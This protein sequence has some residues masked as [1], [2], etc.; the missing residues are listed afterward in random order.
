MYEVSSSS[1]LGKNPEAD[2]ASTGRQFHPAPLPEGF[3]HLAYLHGASRKNLRVGSVQHETRVRGLYDCSSTSIL[4]R[5]FEL[6]DKSQE[7]DNIRNDIRNGGVLSRLNFYR[8]QLASNDLDDNLSS[9]S[10]YLH[11]L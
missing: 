8:N 10:I 9:V 5:C 7:I 2:Y 3:D 11:C 6:T 4:C 1:H